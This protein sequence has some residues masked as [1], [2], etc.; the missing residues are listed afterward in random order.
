MSLHSAYEPHPQRKYCFTALW[1]IKIHNGIMFNFYQGLSH[2]IYKMSCIIQDV[3]YY[4]RRHVL[5]KM[6]MYYTRCTY[7]IQDVHILYK[8]Y[9][10]YTRCTHTRCAYVHV[11]YRKEVHV[12]HYLSICNV[13]DIHVMWVP[14]KFQE[15]VACTYKVCTVQNIHVVYSVLHRMFCVLYMYLYTLVLGKHVYLAPCTVHTWMQLYT[16]V[17]GKHVYLALNHYLTES[18]NQLGSE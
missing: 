15:Y 2:I 1:T 12:L 9:T 4:T 3:M 16:L 6:Y 13:Q 11:L 18:T 10:Y 5:Y 17:L 7:I 8:M 14:E